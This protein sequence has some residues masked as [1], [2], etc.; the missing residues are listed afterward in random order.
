M[1]ISILYVQLR[2]QA[3][4]YIKPVVFSLQ[5]KSMDKQ[6]VHD[7]KLL[8]RT[9]DSSCG[10]AKNPKVMVSVHNLDVFNK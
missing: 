4:L 10:I 3:L 8:S 2:L 7:V 1:L 5:K 9:N 6:S